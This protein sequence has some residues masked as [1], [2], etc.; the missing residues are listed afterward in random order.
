MGNAAATNP[1]HRGKGLIFEVDIVSGQKTGFFLDQRQNRTAVE[2]LSA[3]AEVLNCFS[4]TGAFSLYCLRGGARRVVSVEASAQAN[5]AARRNMVRNGYPPASHP[6]VQA[7]VF[8][9]LRECEEM[10]DLAILDPPVFA[11]SRND[12]RGAERGYGDINL[13][14]A[15]RIRDGGFLA[16]FSCSA[17]VG[18]DL[19]E[20]IVLGAVTDAGRTARLLAV[21]GAGPDHPTNLAHGEGRYLKGLLVSLTS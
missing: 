13:W 4:Y 6:V 10:F 12:V 7:N 19:F 21:L 1:R 11:R 16:T 15:R 18:P 3:G 8:D 17:H 20:R 9:Y 5:E 14:A 2:A